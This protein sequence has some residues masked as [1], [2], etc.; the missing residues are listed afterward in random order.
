MIIYDSINI[1]LR[2]FH[3]K[4]SFRLERYWSIS[5]FAPFIKLLNQ[6]SNNQQLI[7]HQSIHFEKNRISNKYVQ[8]ED[9][10]L[11]RQSKLCIIM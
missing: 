7:H 2:V 3:Q 4:K 11:N 1:F 8:K 5:P 10:N 9:L 6:H